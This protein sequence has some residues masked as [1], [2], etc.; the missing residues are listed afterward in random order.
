M[1]GGRR[2]VAEHC[3]SAY[4][5]GFGLRRRLQRAPLAPGLDIQGDSVSAL[6]SFR[7]VPKVPS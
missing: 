5:S 6:S 1:D 2:G 4:S 7:A 3:T